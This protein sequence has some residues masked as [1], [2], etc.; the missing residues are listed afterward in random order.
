MPRPTAPPCRSRRRG[1][2]LLADDLGSWNELLDELDRQLV[3]SHPGFGLGNV[4]SGI[5]SIDELRDS[6]GPLGPIPDPLIPRARR[7]LVEYEG[8]FARI[9]EAKRVVGDHLDMLQ[10]LR[11]REAAHPVYFDHVG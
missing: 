4:P 11:G 1:C 6:I 7:T 5:W 2:R 10:S 3:R 8:A 9:Q